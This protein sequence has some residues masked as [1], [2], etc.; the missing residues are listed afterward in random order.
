MTKKLSVKSEK[1]MKMIKTRKIARIL[2][3]FIKMDLITLKYF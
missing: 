1:N 3:T 2:K